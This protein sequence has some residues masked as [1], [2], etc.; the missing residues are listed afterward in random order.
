MT[1][2]GRHPRGGPL[3]APQ[4]AL[5]RRRQLLPW[6]IL[7]PQ[8]EGSVE[9]HNLSPGDLEAMTGETMRAPPALLA[10]FTPDKIYVAALG[11]W[12]RS[13]TCT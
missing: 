6:L 12:S 13:S 7:V 11:T 1:G 10:L 8:R 3:G 2:R 5:D 4:R 9:L